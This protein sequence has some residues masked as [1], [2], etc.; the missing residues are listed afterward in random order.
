MSVEIAAGSGLE[1]RTTKK[2]FQ[3]PRRVLDYDVS[4]D[5]QRFLLLASDADSSPPITLIQ[6]W[7]AG[8]GK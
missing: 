3:P 4:A 5:G 7:A 2:L 1:I 6:N 8:P